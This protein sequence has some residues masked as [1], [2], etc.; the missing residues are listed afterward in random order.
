MKTFMNGDF[1][2]SS[3]T[4]R[5]LYHGYAE[6]M[7]IFDCHNH[8][9]P[10]DI[11]RHRRFHNLTELWL[12]CDHYKWRALRAC[13]VDERL[14]SGSAPDYDRFL[15]WAETVPRL[16]GSPLYHWTHLELQRYF[17]IY[18]QL[19][20]AT[21]AMIWDKTECM[22]EGEG[23]DAVSLLGKMNVTALCTTDDPADDLHFH[24]EIAGDSSIP[25][26][27]LPSF[28]PDK[29]LTGSPEAIKANSEK[30]C[31]LY[32][33]DNIEISLGRALDHFCSLGAVDSDHGFSVFEYGSNERLT[34]LMDFL[35]SEYARRGMV[36]QL[37]I[38][39]IRNNSPKLMSLIGPDA[40]G[41]SVG[42]TAD[43]FTL[44]A[45]LGGLEGKN[46]L[47][48]TVLYNMNPCDNMIFSTMAGNFAPKVQFGAAWWF[49]DQLRGI[50]A[51][52][53][54]LMEANSLASSVGML[55]D[56]RSFTSFVRHE[57]FRRILCARLG[58]LVESG[59][60]PEDT[61][62]LGRIVSD[63]CYNNAVNFFLK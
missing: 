61:D 46:S 62:T 36:M 51:Q 44:S 3:E 31:W 9:S 33:S 29:Y 47:P 12:E 30:L 14:I 35:A 53:D 27:V 28:R 37:H 2:L 4:A 18:E 56:S 49:N 21:A 40:G 54:E 6:K 38:G 34:R 8:L 60:Y 63:V 13:G 20:P 19:S 39:P 41:D 55:T 32:S 48:K 10:E 17:G 7:P 1:L 59:L 23:F 50:R 42:R 25:F 52:L 45:F 57:Y 58:E 15:A 22:M 24:R 26:K 43:P 5:T 16:V 11:A